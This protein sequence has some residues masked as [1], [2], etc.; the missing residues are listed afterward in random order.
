MTDNELQI[1][2]GDH[3][4][5]IM[6]WGRAEYKVLKSYLTE[7]YGSK[8]AKIYIR[9]VKWQVFKYKVRKFFHKN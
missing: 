8:F 7:E 4:N 3:W 9:K 5:N 6:S 2:A 1:I